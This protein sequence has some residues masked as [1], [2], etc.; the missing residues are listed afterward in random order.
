MERDNFPDWVLVEHNNWAI[1]I[2]PPNK[3]VNKQITIHIFVSDSLQEIK[4][5]VVIRVRISTKF[6]IVLL[7]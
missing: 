5:T 7:I 1:K 2:T 4:D 3:L 6:I